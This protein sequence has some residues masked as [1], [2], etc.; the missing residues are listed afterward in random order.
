MWNFAWL[1][2][3]VRVVALEAFGESSL[4]VGSTCLE[5]VVLEVLN[6]WNHVLDGLRGRIYRT[7]CVI[8]EDLSTVLFPV[9]PVDDIDI[10][11]HEPPPVF[12]VVKF[13]V[14]LVGHGAR[15]H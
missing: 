5:R 12:F 6:G 9:G 8:T 7:F 1:R 11:F 3:P 4:R 15:T 13:E 2:E 14:F 10:V